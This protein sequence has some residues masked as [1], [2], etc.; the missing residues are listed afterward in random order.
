MNDDE[1]TALRRRAYGRDA[2]IHLDPESLDRLRELEDARVEPVIVEPVVVDEAPFVEVE[3]SEPELEEEAS[4]R[5]SRF[6][7]WLKGLRRSTKLIALGTVL[8]AATL[9]TVL[10]LVQRVQVDPLQVGATQVARLNVDPSY[11]APVIFTG[12]EADAEDVGEVHGYSTFYGMR[13]ITGTRSFFAMPGVPGACMNMFVDANV[14]PTT[15]AFDGPLF[16][17]CAAGAFP[18]TIQFTTDLDALPREL[19]EAFPD[20][21]GFQFVYDVENAQIVVFADRTE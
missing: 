19:I 10:V 3:P 16:S 15:D 8:V 21:T 5:T 20:S 13:V 6:I 18:A 2:D 14:T 4:P 11:E 1:L 12:T 17:G 7:P 9:I